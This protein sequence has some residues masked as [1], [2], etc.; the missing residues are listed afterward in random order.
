MLLRLMV[1]LLLSPL[2]ALA[3]GLPEPQS[4]TVSDFADILPEP[5]EAEVDA[6]IREIRDE[7]GVSI[8]VVTMDRI[9]NYGG[10]GQSLEAY[11]RALFND[12]GIGDAK[13]NDGILILVVPGDREARI[14]LGAGYSAEFD[15]PAQ[16][17]MD[18]AMVPQF[19][20]GKMARGIVEG[21]QAARDA[22]VQ[23]F[24][25]GRVDGLCQPVAAYS[26]RIGREWPSAVPP[27]TVELVA[28]RR[29]R[30]GVDGRIYLTEIRHQIV[31]G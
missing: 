2:A 13:R 31:Y 12:W 26:D 9:A 18:T 5:D 21:V 4:D 28:G 25:E 29:Q 7:T 30:A 3:E 10:G 20:E 24:V 16:W 6:L 22:L 14:D 11:A 19:R 27:R 8:V 23:P 1:V 15:C 17:V